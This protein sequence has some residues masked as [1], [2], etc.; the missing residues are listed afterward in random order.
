MCSKQWVDFWERLDN[1]DTVNEYNYDQTWIDFWKDE[2]LENTLLKS[3]DGF[4]SV[5]KINFFIGTG[6]TVLCCGKGE[7]LEIRNSDGILSESIPSKAKCVGC[8]VGQ[9]QDSGE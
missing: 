1:S 3:M 5:P 8:E 7:R 6:G 9:Y 2:A 4:D